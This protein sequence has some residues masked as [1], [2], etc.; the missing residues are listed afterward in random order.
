MEADSDCSCA[1][2]LEE[3]R[4][5]LATTPCGHVMHYEWYDNLLSQSLPEFMDCS[6]LRMFVE[7]R[8][9]ACPYCRAR[10][11]PG[12]LVRLFYEAPEVDTSNIVPLDKATTPEE[13]RQILISKTQEASKYHAKFLTLQGR[14]QKLEEDAVVATQRRENAEVRFNTT[15]S[16]LNDVWL[17]CGQRSQEASSH[18]KS[19][20]Y[21]RRAKRL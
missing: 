19:C 18:R 7:Q 15:C 16:E 21:D 10:V 12:E 1:I 14:L 2:C 4:K 20:A 8:Q 6:A 3:L 9:T 17:D 13:L 11:R 5:D